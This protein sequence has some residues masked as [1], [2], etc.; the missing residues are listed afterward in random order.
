MGWGGG[1][2]GVGFACMGEDG[3]RVDPN[4]IQPG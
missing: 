4:Q 3:C 1:G 2:G